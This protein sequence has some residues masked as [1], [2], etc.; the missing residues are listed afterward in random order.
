MLILTGTTVK[1]AICAERDG[2][3]S[4]LASRERLNSDPAAPPK[5]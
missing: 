4:M 2:I 5:Q 3:M 1:D